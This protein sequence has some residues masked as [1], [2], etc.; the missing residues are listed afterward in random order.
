LEYYTTLNPNYRVY[1]RQIPQRFI[2][3]CEGRGP[4]E[5]VLHMSQDLVKT[6]HKRVW[7]MFSSDANIAL[8]QQR[9]PDDLRVLAS[10]NFGTFEGQGLVVGLRGEKR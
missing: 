9:P 3:Q 1:A 2:V 6:T 10:Q 5:D 8:F 7:L 4:N